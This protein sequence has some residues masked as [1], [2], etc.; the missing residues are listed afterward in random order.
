MP[1]GRP[2]FLNDLSS[3]SFGDGVW[4][5]V[6]RDLT[7]DQPAASRAGSTALTSSRIPVMDIVD[8]PPPIASLITV[9]TP[10]ADGTTTVSGTSGAVPPEAVVLVASL[11]FAEPNFVRAD[12]D[13]SFDAVIPSAP[14]DIIQIRYRVDPVFREF[15]PE[16]LRDKTHWPGTLVGVPQ[17]E[18]TSDFASAY[19]LNV[20]G[21]ILRG[22]VRTW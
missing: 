6:R 9:G 20:A 17:S 16:G 4:L 19:F 18:P 22:T 12:Q 10:A 15:V 8:H 13:G 7:W 5:Q 1:P 14:G 2:A 21:G 3:L 11:A